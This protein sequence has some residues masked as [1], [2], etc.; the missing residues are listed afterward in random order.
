MKI[1]NFVKNKRDD[2]KKLIKAV[3]EEIQEYEEMLEEIRKL[4]L[5]KYNEREQD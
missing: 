1:I 4:R 2:S 3:E 5:N